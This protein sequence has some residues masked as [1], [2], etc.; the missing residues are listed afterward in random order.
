MTAVVR[1]AGICPATGKH[2]YVERSEAKT[3]ARDSGTRT[4]AGEKL[5]PFRCEACGYFHVG[6]TGGLSR[7]ASREIHTARYVE[8]YDR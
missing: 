3:V 4:V 5:K 7:A 1:Y 8:G 2:Q 6:T